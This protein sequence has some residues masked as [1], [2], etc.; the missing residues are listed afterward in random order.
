MPKPQRNV[1]IADS[2]SSKNATLGAIWTKYKRL[3]ELRSEAHELAA[4]SAECSNCVGTLSSPMERFVDQ[5]ESSLVEL[6]SLAVRTPAKN[7]RDI[8]CKKKILA[9]CI[10][11]QSSDLVS[12][13]AESL[14][15]DVSQGS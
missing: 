14:K 6:A 8:E 15:C 11:H 12:D 1:R 9:D 4:S 2:G 10:A 13:L 5:I 3:C 7:S